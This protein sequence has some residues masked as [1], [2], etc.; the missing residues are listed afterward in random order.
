MRETERRI[1]RAFVLGALTLVATGASHSGDL[2]LLS[3]G[4]LPALRVVK[5]ERYEGKALYGYID[6]G[7]ELYRE[8]GFVRLAVQQ[9]EYGGEELTA[10]IYQMIDTLAAFGIFSVHRFDAGAVDSLGAASC[11]TTYHAQFA[12]GEFFIRVVNATGTPGARRATLAVAGVLRSKLSPPSSSVSALP[13]PV[14]WTLCPDIRSHSYFRGVL[15]VQNGFPDW[16]DLVEGIDKFEMYLAKAQESGATIADLRLGDPSDRPG[17]I[18]RWRE[19]GDQARACWE[20][21]EGRLILLEGGQGLDSL[22]LAVS[23]AVR[24]A[25]ENR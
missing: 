1:S 18:K 12:A 13:S 19:A 9:L 25:A 10:E 11:S 5:T 23:A 21:G 8:Y 6:G 3:G 2:P 20:I 4:E 16:S 14:L 17:F 24:G 7:A 15:A 22:R